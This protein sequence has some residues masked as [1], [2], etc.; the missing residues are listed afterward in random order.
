[1]LV[2]IGD[3]RRPV[4]SIADVRRELAVVSVISDFHVKLQDFPA[5][6]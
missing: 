6:A 1:M 2:A 3:G 5:R 4:V